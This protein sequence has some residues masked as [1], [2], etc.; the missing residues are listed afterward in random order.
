VVASRVVE[1]LAILDTEG[2]AVERFIALDTS[3]EERS[4]LLVFL[5]GYFGGCLGIALGRRGERWKRKRLVRRESGRVRGWECDVMVRRRLDER[6]QAAQ[7]SA[8]LRGVAWMWGDSER[9]ETEYGWL[10][11]ER[12]SGSRQAGRWMDSGRSVANDTGENEPE[13]VEG[14]EMRRVVLFGAG[15][16]MLCFCWSWAAGSVGARRGQRR[17]V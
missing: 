7:A 4:A 16:A 10:D 5:G 3:S 6:V 12:Q 2:V 1:S 13:A 14:C 11:R 17:L 15:A 8:R 9:E